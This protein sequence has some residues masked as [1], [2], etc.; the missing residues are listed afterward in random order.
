MW[1]KNAPGHGGLST[2][3]ESIA[4]EDQN[5]KNYPVHEVTVETKILDQIILKTLRFSVL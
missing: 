5:Q 1:F 4:R 2:M 3:D